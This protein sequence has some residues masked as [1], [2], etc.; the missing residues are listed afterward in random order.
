MTRGVYVEGLMEES[1][2]D[3]AAALDIMMRGTRNRRVGETAMN[4]QSSRSHSVF[5]LWIEAKVGPCSVC[6][7]CTAI[8]HTILTMSPYL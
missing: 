6:A 5:T 8:L 2:T 1:V 3:S 4:R 7:L